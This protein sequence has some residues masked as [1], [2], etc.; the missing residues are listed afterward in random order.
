MCD[1]SL[2]SW[3]IVVISLWKAWNLSCTVLKSAAFSFMRLV[4]ED[5]EG[6]VLF[7]VQPT[8]STALLSWSVRKKCHLTWMPLCCSK[9]MMQRNMYFCMKCCDT[10]TLKISTLCHGWWLWSAG[11]QSF[12]QWTY[13][14]AY[15]ISCNFF[16]RNGIAKWKTVPW[17]RFHQLKTEPTW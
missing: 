8:P 11:H 13:I 1:V 16:F 3:S 12:P 15:I 9:L 2:V 5:N 6:V 7:I 17:N 14:A 4:L 10:P